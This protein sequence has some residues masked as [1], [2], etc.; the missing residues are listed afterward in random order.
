MGA[1]LNV[2]AASGGSTIVGSPRIYTSGTAVTETVPAT[3]NSVI[4]EVYGGGSSGACIATAGPTPGGGT[5]GAYSIKTMTVVAGNTFTYTVAALVSGTGGGVNPINIGNAST[6][7]NG[8]APATNINSGQAGSTAPSGGDTNTS[9][10]GP[11][12]P[13]GGAGAG[14]LGGAG[15]ATLGASGTAP[16]GAGAGNNSSNTPGSGARGQIIFTYYT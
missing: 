12:N 3:A 7:V 13:A 2:I 1:I 4:I 8:T 14:P 10:S 16:G 5:G 9:G 6:V 15:G 11:T